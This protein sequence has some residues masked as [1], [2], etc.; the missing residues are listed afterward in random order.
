ML[1]P[2]ESIED[3]GGEGGVKYLLVLL[4]DSYS[5][6]KARSRLVRHR[7]ILCQSQEGHKYVISSQARDALDY[8]ESTVQ[9]QGQLKEIIYLIYPSIYSAKNDAIKIFVVSEWHSIS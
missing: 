1:L 6:N 7:C 9:T 4:Q 8:G 2:K 3:G 5:E